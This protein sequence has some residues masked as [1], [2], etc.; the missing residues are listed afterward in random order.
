MPEEWA[1]ADADRIGDVLDT[2]IDGDGICDDRNA[3]GTPDCEE[4]DSDGDGYPQAGA[5]L[6][7]AF[8]FVASEWRDSDGDGTG[9][10]AD[11]D[12]DGDGWSDAE[13]RAAGTDPL[14]A[15][16]FPPGE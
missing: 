9:D 12:D 8:P 11:E 14:N 16:S 4:L 3:N 13:E 1:D 15:V 5:L 6:S 2:D 10:N 7:D